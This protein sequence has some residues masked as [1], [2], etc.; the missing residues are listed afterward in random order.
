MEA[1][2][3]KW[4]VCSIKLLFL[5]PAALHSHYKG[6]LSTSVIFLSENVKLNVPHMVTTKA[7]IE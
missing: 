3:G 6:A 2:A 7:T 4:T 1:F 5:F